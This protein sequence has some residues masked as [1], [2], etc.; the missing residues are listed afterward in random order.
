MLSAYYGQLNRLPLWVNRLVSTLKVTILVKENRWIDNRS[1]CQQL[2]WALKLDWQSICIDYHYLHSSCPVPFGKSAAL[3]GAFAWFKI[4]SVRRCIISSCDFQMT[5]QWHH[6]GRDGVS[7]HRCLDCLLSH[8][9]R[10]RSKKHQS[11]ALLALLWGE[12]TGDQWI[13]LT[14]GQ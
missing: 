11:S 14:K 6:N 2:E 5:L 9:F 1:G 10:L 4:I 13:P 12:S 7:N 3:L 8:L